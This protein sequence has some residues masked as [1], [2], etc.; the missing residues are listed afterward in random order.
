M[1]D[2]AF[3]AHGHCSDFGRKNGNSRENDRLYKLGSAVYFSGHSGKYAAQEKGENAL[4]PAPQ[5]LPHYNRFVF[6]LF[7][8]QPTA[9]KRQYTERCHFH[10]LR[11]SDRLY[12]GASE[13]KTQQNKI[14]IITILT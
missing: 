5:L 3:A 14:I 1:A 7:C 4:L 9:G 6:R 10:P 11:K 12:F 13:E 2:F 8:G